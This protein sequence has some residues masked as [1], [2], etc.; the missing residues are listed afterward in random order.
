MTPRRKQAITYLV[1]SVPMLWWGASQFEMGGHDHL[2]AIAL[3]ISLT[4]GSLFAICGILMFFTT[5][6][7][8]EK[9]VAEDTAI[10]LA[11]Q[12]TELFDKEV[13]N[14]GSGAFEEA[15]TALDSAEEP[16]NGVTVIRTLSS[17]MVKSFRS[18]G[19][20]VKDCNAERA[21]IRATLNSR[22]ISI[23]ED[24]NIEVE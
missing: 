24:G 22:G 7:L 15:H 2:M 13:T 14:F 20:T 5:Y 18:L 6:K 21:E 16:T 23:N 11:P 10:R 1:S 17:E 8:G 19:E 9:S 4:F 12:Q 3:S